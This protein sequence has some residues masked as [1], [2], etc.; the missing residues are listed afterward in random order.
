MKD[1]YFDI[2][3][4]F[5]QCASG[6]DREEAMQLVR[7]SFEDDYNISL[8]DCEITDSNE[9]EIEIYDNYDNTLYGSL[10]IPEDT[11][12]TAVQSAIYEARDNDTKLELTYD[13][14]LDIVA[15]KFSARFEK[16]SNKE[17]EKLFI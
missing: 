16:V 9:R 2:D 13:D 5:T 10:F 11:E 15:K 1:F 7:D 12:L 17:K 3:L 4:H 8:D 6:E 14:I